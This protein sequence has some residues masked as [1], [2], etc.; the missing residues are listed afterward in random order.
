MSYTVPPNKVLHADGA[1]LGETTVKATL[2]DRP[3][4]AGAAGEHQGVRRMSP[5]SKRGPG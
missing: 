4:G 2:G 1:R 3:P 5:S